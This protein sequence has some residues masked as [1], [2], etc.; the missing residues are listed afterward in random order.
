MMNSRKIGPHTNILQIN[1]EGISLS[2]SSI[3][4]KIALDY[5]IDI[6]LLQETHARSPEDLSNRCKINNFELVDSISDPQHGSATYKKSGIHCTS[7]YKSS[8]NTIE[9][10]AHK[11]GSLNV[12]NIYKPPRSNWSTPPLPLFPHPTIYMGDFNSHHQNWGYDQNDI[13]GNSVNEWINTNNHELVFNIKDRGTF[14]SARW[15]KNYNPDLCVVS[16][17]PNCVQSLANRTVLSGFP[18]S[19]HRPVLLR[20]GLEIP[21]I[22]SIP[23][24]RWN[25]FKGKW[26]MFASLLDNELK[27]IVPSVNN[28]INFANAVYKTAQKTIPRGYRISYIPGWDRHCDELYKIYEETSQTIFGD[29]LINYL[30]E[31]RRH[32][33]QRK[34][35]DINFIHS[36]RKGWNTINKLSKS[37]YQCPTFND[38]VTPNQIAS[39]LLKLSRVVMDKK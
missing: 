7:L 38:K 20:Y 2:K 26:T 37:S 31:K 14:K 19:Q 10:M 8:S 1:V 3:I 32:I 11:F 34:T 36:S 17:D 28:Y 23:R 27:S 30:N 16:R 25:F 22:Q 39:R 33:W 6:I 18:H 5:K 29:E 4:S 21:L 24:P 12:V 35:A 13:N 15:N 9:I